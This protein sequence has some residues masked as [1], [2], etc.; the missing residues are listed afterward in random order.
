MSDGQPR[1][2]SYEWQMLREDVLQRDGHECQFC[3]SADDLHAHHIHAVKD[4][5]EDRLENLT[6]L[7]EECHF[8]LHRVGPN[9]AGRFTVDLLDEESATEERDRVEDLLGAPSREDAFLISSE[10][11]SGPVVYHNEGAAHVNISRRIERGESVTVEKAE[12]RKG[13]QKQMEERIRMLGLLA[14]GAATV[15]LERELLVDLQEVA[16][17]GA[18]EM[19]F[20][21]KLADIRASREER[22]PDA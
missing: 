1:T 13:P 3:E 22:D 17:P 8:T 21:N 6:T 11:G 14:E 20:E 19:E 5:G 4:G 2:A 12:L 15:D 9:D 18:E 10:S 7:C 16:E